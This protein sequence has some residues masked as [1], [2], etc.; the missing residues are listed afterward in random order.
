MRK[1]IC[2]VIIATYLLTGCTSTHKIAATDPNALNDFIAKAKQD[3]AA[4]EEARTKRVAPVTYR[5]PKN[6]EFLGQIRSPKMPAVVRAK[7]MIRGLASRGKIPIKYDFLSDSNPMINNPLGNKKGLILKDYF[8]S[9]AVQSDWAYRVENGVI[10]WSD[11]TSTVL[12]LTPIVGTTNSV[13]KSQSGNAEEL[14][15]TNSLTS[16]TDAYGEIETLVTNILAVQSGPDAITTDI[17]DTDI[18]DTDT[19]TDTDLTPSFYVSKAANLLYLSATPNKVREVTRVIATYNQRVTQRAVIS[20]T[21][22]DVSFDNAERRSLDFDLL[23]NAT[24]SLGISGNS[25]AS[26][27][28]SL[29]ISRSTNTE[30][31]SVSDN[32]IINWIRSQ[33]EVA[34]KNDRK[35]EVLNNRAITFLDTV[36]IEYIKKSSVEKVSAATDS[37]T[38][39]TIEVGAHKV[40]RSINA[41]VTI[42]DNVVHLQL[43][44]ND[45]RVVDVKEESLGTGDGFI[46][47]YD[48]ANEDR[49]IPLTLADGES[50]MLTY[51]TTE[52]QKKASSRNVLVPF[53]LDGQSDSSFDKQTVIIVG[54]D[55]IKP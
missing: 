40:G 27:A 31:R 30:A 29:S 13:L 46:R 49:V 20:M 8:D 32:L 26:G 43:T 36:E 5:L 18:A 4:A 21:V 28:D 53:L 34:Y 22:Y 7:T 19:D 54:A 48:I 47:L 11:W 15:Q 39:Q 23:R 45:R 37:P 2:L 42:V 12:S 17:A 9:I 52:D 44:I 1:I 6:A 35:F 14:L 16:T 24:H 41:F 50:R 33:G 55:I 10:V 51:F 25:S 3:L 38:T